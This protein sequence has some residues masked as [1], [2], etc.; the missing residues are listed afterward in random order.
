MGY[1]IFIRFSGMNNKLGR[2][3]NDKEDINW[4]LLTMPKNA[5][6][7]NFSVKYKGLFILSKMQIFVVRNTSS[8]KEA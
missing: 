8:I 6:Y 5:F 4:V 3:Y 7:V 2:M 1:L